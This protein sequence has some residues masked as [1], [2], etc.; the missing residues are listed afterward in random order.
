MYFRKAAQNYI[1]ELYDNYP[2]LNEFEI[3]QR[4][5]IFLFHLK[6]KLAYDQ[7]ENFRKK[8]VRSRNAGTALPLFDLNNFKF[9]QD[10][11]NLLPSK[12]IYPRRL[13]LGINTRSTNYKQVGKLKLFVQAASYSFG[14]DH[15]TGSG[16]LI[17]KVIPGITTQQIRAEYANHPHHSAEKEAYSIEDDESLPIFERALTQQINNKISQITRLYR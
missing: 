12:V 5:Y 17:A 16:S 9:P 13:I 4:L 10:Y 14:I 6:F 3:F 8:V 1:D 7:F 15:V 11:D 2:D